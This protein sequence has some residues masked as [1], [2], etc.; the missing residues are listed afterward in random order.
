M[1]DVQYL[2]RINIGNMGQ[3]HNG[4]GTGQIIHIKMR[5]TMQEMAWLCETDQPVQCPKTVVSRVDIVVNA[6]GRRVGDEDV[7]AA[8][9]LHAVEQDAGDHAKGAEVSLGLGI[10]IGAIRAIAY[11]TPKTAD[12]KSFMTHQFEVQID[13]ALGARLLARQVFVGIMV[14]WH[15]EHGHVQHGH[16]VFEIGVG[17]VAAANDQL[18][19]LEL[20]TGRKG[21]NSIEGLITNRQNFHNKCI[22]P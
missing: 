22:L 5:M 13:A 10:L 9:V 17:E 14:A 1:T 4:F 20:S 2:V 3:V 15:I 12:Q 7:Q 18:H 19:I 11:R 21:I 6:E 8:A 16:Q